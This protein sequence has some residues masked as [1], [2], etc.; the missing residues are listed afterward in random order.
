MAKLRKINALLFAQYQATAAR[1]GAE[2]VDSAKTVERLLQPIPRESL[3]TL[4]D[5]PDLQTAGAL[6]KLAGL[7]THHLNRDPQYALAIAQLAVSV[8]DGLPDNTYPKPVMAQIR[9]IALKDLGKVTRTLA[10]HQE[11]IE[12]LLRAVALLQDQPTLGHDLA[13][14]RLHLALT[15]Q[16]L[17]RFT[18]AFTLTRD[19][20]QIFAAHSDAHMVFIAGI[21][22]GALLQRLAR[23][24]EARETYLLLLASGSPDTESEAALRKNIGLCSIELGDFI[25]AE[26]NLAESIRLYMKDLGQPIETLRAQTGYGRLLIRMGEIEHGI[27]QLKPVR[28]AFLR[29]SMI[30]EAGICALEIIEGL[31]TRNKPQDAERLARM[32][33]AEFSRAQLNQRAITALGYLSRTIYRRR[34]LQ[35]LSST[36]YATTSSRSEQIRSASFCGV[37]QLRF[38]GGGRDRNSDQIA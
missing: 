20:K 1:L 6:E 10:R 12:I 13:L 3:W 19:S 33:I 25:E 34:T 2:R 4:T 26:S 15:Y 18:E 5:H 11:S 27:A 30:E 36:M 16:E 14:V 31:L 38:G 9:A 22:E 32:V 7:V 21:T 28:R 23:F 29:H 37:R 17:D 8:A 35:S 24:R